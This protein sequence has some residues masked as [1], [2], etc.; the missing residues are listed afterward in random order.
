MAGA[1]AQQLLQRVGVK[2]VAYV[3]AV[4]SVKLNKCYQDLDLSLIDS[5]IVRCPDTEIANKMITNFG[6][7]IK[8]NMDILIS[9][10]ILIDVGKLLEYP[11]CCINWLIENKINDSS[12]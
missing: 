1:I 5:N 2:I 11:H 7:K 3:S 6:D 10:S 9:G 4:G 8:I 12:P